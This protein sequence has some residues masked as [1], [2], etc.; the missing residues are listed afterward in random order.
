MDLL[1]RFAST[2]LEDYKIEVENKK[3]FYELL[4]E[5]LSPKLFIGGLPIEQ[6]RD[7][8]RLKRCSIIVGTLGRIMQL[9]QE[10]ILTLH[11][12]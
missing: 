7:I 9:L 4:N 8:L 1:T 3:M 6:D 5:V 12:I 11:N 10:N 2:I